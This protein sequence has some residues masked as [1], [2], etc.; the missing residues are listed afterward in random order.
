MATVMCESR[1]RTT[2]VRVRMIDRGSVR[3][4]EQARTRETSAIA[5]V[6]G[7]SDELV[8]GVVFTK[9]DATSQRATP[10]HEAGNFGV[11]FPA[12][13]RARELVSGR[14][15]ISYCAGFVRRTTI[16]QNTAN[17]C[18]IMYAGDGDAAANL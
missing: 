9:T 5:S 6:D 3:R 16:A 10:A 13:M 15:Q 8:D 1:L 11:G 7:L 18:A 17:K 2:P 12:R 14:I 4:A